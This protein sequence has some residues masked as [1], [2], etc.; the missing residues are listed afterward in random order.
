MSLCVSICRVP[1]FQDASDFDTPLTA[2]EDAN[3]VSRTEFVVP[4]LVFQGTTPSG[5]PVT[6]FHREWPHTPLQ[7]MFWLTVTSIVCQ[8]MGFVLQGGNLQD[9][10]RVTLGLGMNVCT[11]VCC[12]ALPTVTATQPTSSPNQPSDIRVGAPSLLPASC[13]LSITG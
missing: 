10:W 3:F 8:H 4:G 5:Q 2:G 7:P 12:A 1:A 11:C 9:V 13:P 6:E